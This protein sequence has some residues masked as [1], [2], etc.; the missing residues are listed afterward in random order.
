V[1]LQEAIQETKGSFNGSLS[2]GIIPTLAPFLLPLFL[3]KLVAQYP[4]MRFNINEITTNELL[5]RIKN[6]ELDLGILSLPVEDK[7]LTQLS[8][9]EEDFL[10]YD[11]NKQ[12]DKKR[13]KIK[14]IDVSR[15]WLLEESH[16]LTSQI[17]KICLLQKANDSKQHLVFRSGSILSLIEL[18]HMNKG[19]TLLPRLATYNKGL[20]DADYLSELASPVPVREIGMVT[21]PNFAKQRWVD[22]LVKQ[23]QRSVKPI[24]KSKGKRKVIAPF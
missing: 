21:H 4:E 2:I 5:P 16:C 6:R 10:V 8:L 12:H 18:V 3:E 1:Q 13:Y 14:D 19:L 15:L 17:E 11:V 24:L 20:I 23:I 9:F 7:E 22:I